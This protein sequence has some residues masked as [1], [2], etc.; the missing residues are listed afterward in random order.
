M[1]ENGFWISAWSLVVAVII[2]I[3]TAITY[4]NLESNSSIERMVQAGA[5]PMDAAC[6][7]EGMSTKCL[8]HIASQKSE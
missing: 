6:S 7:I 2:S 3:V 1:S 8:I 5:N 4:Y